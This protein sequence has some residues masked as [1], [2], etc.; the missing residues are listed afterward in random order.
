MPGHY[1]RVAECHNC[2]TGTASA[3]G[4]QF[5][6]VDE[7]RKVGCPDCS[8]T[9]CFVLHWKGLRR[10]LSTVTAESH[11]A[12]LIYSVHDLTPVHKAQVHKAPAH[13]RAGTSSS[14]DSFAEA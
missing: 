13:R 4:R 11:Q 1:D 6:P 9:R 7:P 8:H 3:G 2:H 10:L 5:E 12:D 14:A